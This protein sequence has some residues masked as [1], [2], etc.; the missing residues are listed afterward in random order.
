MRLAHVLDVKAVVQ[1]QV[2][3]EE[4]Y[5]QVCLRERPQDT[6]EHLEGKNARLEHGEERRFGAGKKPQARPPHTQFAWLGGR[7]GGRGD[8]TQGRSVHEAYALSFGPRFYESTVARTCASTAGTHAWKE[9]E[10]RT[11]AHSVST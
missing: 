10:A 3:R 6:A 7:G 5:A 4:S 1:R 2:L 11:D 8:C 9:P